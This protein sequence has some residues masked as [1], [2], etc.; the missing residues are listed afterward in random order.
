IVH[1]VRDGAEAVSGPG[2]EIVAV[3]VRVFVEADAVA[4]HVRAPPPLRHHRGRQCRRGH[5]RVHERSSYWHT[6]YS[7]PE[8]PTSPAIVAHAAH[9][10]AHLFLMSIASGEISEPIGPAIP[11]PVE[12]WSKAEKTCRR[13][14]SA[15]PSC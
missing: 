8:C 1:P 12:R 5:A 10:R 4:R 7:S 14:R 9:W 6:P 13:R 2:A 3:E 11:H 15:S